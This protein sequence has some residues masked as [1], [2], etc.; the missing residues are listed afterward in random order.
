VFG[1]F[2]RWISSGWWQVL[3]LITLASEGFL[4]V[5][6]HGSPAKSRRSP[7]GRLR[8]TLAASSLTVRH[9]RVSFPREEIEVILKAVDCRDNRLMTACQTPHGQHLQQIACPKWGRGTR[10]TWPSLKTGWKGLRVAAHKARER[11]HITL[12]DALDLTRL[13]VYLSY[14]DEDY[15]SNKAKRLNRDVATR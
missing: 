3:P 7:L 1:R 10:L 15:T 6:E 11:G 9:A 2:S 12:A 14:V 13:E 5:G 4:G 8:T